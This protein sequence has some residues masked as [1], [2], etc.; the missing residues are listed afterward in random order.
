MIIMKTKYE[1]G[2][3]ILIILFVKF[4]IFILDKYFNL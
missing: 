3:K 2:N 1:F 4:V